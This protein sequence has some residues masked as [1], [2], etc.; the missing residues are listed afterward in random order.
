MSNMSKKKGCSGWLGN[1]VTILPC[2]GGED[3]ASVHLQIA[4][5]L[6]KRGSLERLGISYSYLPT[7]YGEFYYH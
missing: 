7:W 4:R 1:S 5:S 2:Y 6:S 3:M